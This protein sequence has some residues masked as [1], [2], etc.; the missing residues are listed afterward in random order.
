MDPIRNL[1]INMARDEA[2]MDLCGIED[3]IGSTFFMRALEYYARNKNCNSSILIKLLDTN[4]HLEK[5]TIYNYT[6][7]MYAFICHGTNPNFDSAIFLKLLDMNCVPEK[8]TEY[9]GETALMFA[10]KYYGQNPKCNSHVFSKMLDMNCKP[11]QIR[12]DGSTA[13]SY[14]FQNYGKN[15]NYDIK[16]FLKLINLLH[17]SITSLELIVLLNAN[18]DDQRLKAKIYGEYNHNKR[19]ALV[20]NRV[21]KR[22]V[23]GKLDSIYIL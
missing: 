22:R 15:P 2:R 1:C 20:N 5:V 12:N 17:P 13:L 16:I 4:C 10:F 18:T 8:I 6:A 9:Y 14:A 21:F 11:K 3:E 23:M 7:L 19:R